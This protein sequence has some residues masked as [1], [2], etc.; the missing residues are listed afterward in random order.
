MRRSYHDSKPVA[1]EAVGN[2]NY[3][4]RWDIKS[5][6]VD[7]G[8]DMGEREQWSCEEA[9]IEGEPDYGKLVTAVIRKDY[10]ADAE[11]AL[12][13]KYNAYQQGISDDGSIVGE[14]SDFLSLVSSVK[15]M[16]RKDLG[17]EEEASAG[18]SPRMADVARL[19][20]S[21][22]NTMSLTESEALAVKSLYPEW[23][24]GVD[25]KK[26]ERYNYEGSLWEVVQDHSTQENWKPS[27]ATL[28]LWKK[29]DAG[30]HAGTV[31]DPIPYE[32]GMALYLGKYYSQFGVTY[33]C[34]QASG[35]LVYDLYQVPAIAEAV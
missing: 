18:V 9:L 1:I 2:G 30:E 25:V 6:T 3:F 35:P 33:K 29:V 17:I 5:E 10:S 16:V 19:L 28:S 20:V 15:A 8:P 12:V 24:A 13:N 4:Y 7:M 31:E 14:Y 26:G 34:I 22:I 21:R 23:K 27:Q 32:Q 11:M